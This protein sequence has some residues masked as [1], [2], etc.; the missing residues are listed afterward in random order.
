MARKAAQ[1]EGTPARLRTAHRTRP[2]RAPSRARSARQSA[3]HALAQREVGRAPCRHARNPAGERR[4]RK[5]LPA[6][7]SVAALM[8]GS[9]A[10]S[11]A[12][13]QVRYPQRVTPSMVGLAA[14]SGPG[15]SS[16]PAL[17]RTME[18]RTAAPID[19][20]SGESAA[21][22]KAPS[23]YPASP[24]L[25]HTLVS[26]QVPP[27]HAFVV[28]QSLFVEHAEPTDPYGWH[29]SVE[30]QMRLGPPPARPPRRS[31]G[32][33]PRARFPRSA[34]HP[35]SSAG[36]FIRFRASTRP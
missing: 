10:A 36:A 13:T 24:G 33:P 15:I 11:V 17:R 3:G 21:A 27:M 14:R 28:Q 18:G 7:V 34:S 12:A 4:L 2:G 32:H 20:A 6:G 5:A 26:A 35:Q 29:A 25:A 16:P 19:S 31:T 8:S 30:L 1:A 9:H 22:T 23:P